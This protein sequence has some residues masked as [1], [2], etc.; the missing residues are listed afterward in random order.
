MTRPAVDRLLGWYVR[1]I[2]GG[3][4]PFLVA[5]R[6]YLEARIEPGSAV[7]D[8]GGGDGKLANG[9]A[10]DARR[11]FIVD[12]ETTSLPGSDAGHYAGTLARAKA[13]R[14]S[15]KVCPIKGDGTS[16]PFATAS[17]D[18]LVSSQFLEH[19][20]HAARTPFFVECARVLKPHGI[21]ALSTP[22]GDHIEKRRFW[23]SALA[24]TVLPAACIRRLPR[25]MRGLWLEQDVA[26]WEQSVGH[27]DHGCRLAHLRAVSKAAGFEE[28]DTRCQH[29]W[30][31]S[32]WFE[33]LCT[34]PAC[35]LAAL[36]LVRL[37]YW[38]EMHIGT[39]DGINLL[40][41]FRKCDGREA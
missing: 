4:W 12:K 25:L 10:I 6:R 27:Y 33:L 8:I 21:L 1:W 20:D 29:T 15:H 17:L 31:T 34:F 5:E 2:G 41:T 16:L 18:A 37:L 38:L 3:D 28:I 9:L 35:F 22:N 26:S 24:R 30:L 23:F 14:V 36:P 13:G 7:A 19:I 11:V 32:F 39:F 40:M